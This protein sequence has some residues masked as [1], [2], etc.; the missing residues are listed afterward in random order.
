MKLTVI[1]VLYNLKVEK[2]KT[3]QTLMKSSLFQSKYRNDVQ[4]IIYDN[5]LER[6]N[7]DRKITNDVNISYKHD[8]RNL[9]IATAYNYAWEQAK[10][11]SEWLLLLD[12]DTEITE[13]FATKLMTLNGDWK[14]IGAI[15]PKIEFNG[16]HISPVFS[17]SLRPLK[18][19]PPSIGIQEEPVMA[20]NSGSLINMDFLNQIGGFN[21]Q[22]PLD[23]LDHWIFYELYRKGWKVY[24]QDITLNHDLSVMDY[25]SISLN[26]YKSI[27]DS[28]VLFYSTYKKE[29]QKEY[30]QQLL[31]RLL[32]QLVVVKNKRLALYTFSKLLKL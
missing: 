30:K 8:K 27:L 14:G 12:H 21:V 1:V 2:S 17:K 23:Y 9:G 20:I 24:I 10:K 11:H 18:T 16:T 13:E 22:F 5:S 7:L 4:F 26:R 28:E 25:N 32:K 31:K 29:L 15:V 3:V 19:E 6:Q